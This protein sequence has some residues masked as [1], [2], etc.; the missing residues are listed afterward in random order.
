M[1]VGEGTGG[2]VDVLG[3]PFVGIGLMYRH[4][5]FRQIVGP[6][7]QQEHFYPDYDP[8]RVP[9]LPV[10]D[11]AGQDLKVE[12]PLGDRT[13]RARVWK[14]QVGR[15]PVLLLDTDLEG[16]ARLGWPAGEDLDED[17]YDEDDDE[18]DEGD[19]DD[20]GGEAQLYGY[21]E[22]APE[23]VDPRT[24]RERGVDEGWEE[25]DREDPYDVDDA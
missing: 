22:E 23:Y 21:A 10:V 25:L 9:L 12:L 20:D 8:A 18:Y 11:D 3:L 1:A 7:G 5:Y 19:Y 16:D 14:A 2:G 4:G 13:I 15:I 6:D 17:E 24:S